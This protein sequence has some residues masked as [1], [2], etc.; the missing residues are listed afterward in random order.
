MRGTSLA[1][2]YIAG[3]LMDGELVKT[4][5]YA[6]EEISQIEETVYV[7]DVA[8][9]KT[10][11][12]NEEL[13]IG[14]RRDFEETPP[15]LPPE[16]EKQA[17]TRSEIESVE[18]VVEKEQANQ[19]TEGVGEMQV[20]Q[21]AP[22]PK[23]APSLQPVRLSSDVQ[24]LSATENETQVASNSSMGSEP[25]QVTTPA[26]QVNVPDGAE[27]EVVAVLEQS[28]KKQ[29]ASVV[30]DEPNPE[31]GGEA[32]VMEETEETPVP[33]ASPV[34]PGEA[35]PG[36]S[37]PEQ[38]ARVDGSDDK[39]ESETTLVA[40]QEEGAPPDVQK[41]ELEE[42]ALVSESP[43]QQNIEI[44]L[45]ENRCYGCNLEGADLSGRNLGEADL[46]GA[47]L[48]GANLQGVDLEE[49]NLKGSDLSGA[50]LRHADLRRADLYKANLTKANLT[51][52]KLE[53]TLLDDA[54]LTD[55]I[56]YQGTSMMM[57]DQ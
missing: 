27:E 9:S 18:A 34:V 33:V 37:Q 41:S 52:A 57:Q 3:I 38:A 11:P 42:P 44:L 45:D 49:A 29:A 17:A 56:G 23:T 43:V 24:D 7:E 28:P 22:E 54:D 14:A 36:S 32:I 19:T 4:T 53:E 55:V 21:V 47:N 39:S 31:A 8:K 12:V 10:A 5:P 15:P 30:M 13:R 46:E 6:Q 20:D 1:G 35:E 26:E 50:D 16:V 25:A 48:K 51:D 2:A 40:M